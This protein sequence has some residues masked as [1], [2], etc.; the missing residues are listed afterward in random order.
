MIEGMDL[1]KRLIWKRRDAYRRVFLDGRGQPQGD[2]AIVLS[3]LRRF[4]CANK[5]T[6]RL[7]KEGRVDAYAMAVAEGRREVW[8]RLNEYLHLDEKIIVNLIEQEQ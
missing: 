2:A 6:I 4:C 7:D 8:N 3:D 5:A 1:I